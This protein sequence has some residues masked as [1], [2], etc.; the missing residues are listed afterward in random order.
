MIDLESITV[1]PLVQMGVA[2][3]WII[4]LIWKEKKFNELIKTSLE[5]NTKA[6][7][8]LEYALRDDDGK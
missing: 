6:L 7:E 8:R 5:N 2:G 4:Y 3:L 1:T